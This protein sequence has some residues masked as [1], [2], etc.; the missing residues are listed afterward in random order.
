MLDLKPVD[1]G[2]I[3]PRGTGGSVTAWWAAGVGCRS[4][5]WRGNIKY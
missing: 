4:F 1:G 2:G 5:L 3:T